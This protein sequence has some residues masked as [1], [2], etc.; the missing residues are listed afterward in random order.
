MC[1][2]RRFWWG[3]RAG[4]KVVL[5]GWWWNM[6]PPGH[7]RLRNASLTT[8]NQETVIS[9]IYILTKLSA[10]KAQPPYGV[11]DLLIRIN[12]IRGEPNRRQDIVDL[13]RHF[14]TRHQTVLVTF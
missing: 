3:F 8:H 2:F 1:S 13:K 6:L 11:S 12:R 7:T 14:G 5:T 10:H 9:D 4:G